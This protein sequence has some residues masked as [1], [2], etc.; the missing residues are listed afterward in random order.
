MV[1]IIHILTLSPCELFA[2]E[3][4]R[5]VQLFVKEIILFG[6]VSID[7]FVSID[8][9]ILGVVWHFHHNGLFVVDIELAFRISQAFLVIGVG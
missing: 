1:I 2:I 9:L 3:T 4:L 8:N 7:L 6:H 5:I